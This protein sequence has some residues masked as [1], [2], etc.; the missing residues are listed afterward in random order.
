M[1]NLHVRTLRLAND[2]EH[3]REQLVS[4]VKQSASLFGGFYVDLKDL[5]KFL[6]NALADVRYK[7][8]NIEVIPSTSVEVGIPA[9]E[10]NRA[11]VVAVNLGTGQS[12]VVEG[13]WSGGMGTSAVDRGGRYAVPSN[14]AVISGEY[15]G[16]GSFARLYVH[17]DNVA[18]LI[19]TDS[20]EELSEDEKYALTY[21]K[22]FN[23]QGRKDAFRDKRLGVYGVTNPLVQ[24]LASKGLVKARGRA[25]VITTK[26]KNVVQGLPRKYEQTW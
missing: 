5:P 2:D 9:F 8:R 18:G 23:S 1:P 13:D 10:G 11:Y 19:E 17:P 12:K 4:L 22:I 25:V 3:L 26:G 21:I 7:R 6:R 20:T 16:R 15:G 14:G 24:S